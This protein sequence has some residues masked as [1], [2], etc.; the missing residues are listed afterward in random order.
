MS[1][2]NIITFKS[3]DEIAFAAHE[4]PFPASRAMPNWWKQSNSSIVMNQDHTL[5]YSTFKK[6]TPMLDAI[7]AGYIIPLHSDI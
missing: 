4:R 2:T 1:K 7:S 6:C 5:K 3:V